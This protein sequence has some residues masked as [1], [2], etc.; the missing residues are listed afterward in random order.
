MV[1]EKKSDCRFAGRWAIIL[2]DV[3]DESHIQHAVGFIQYRIP[4]VIEGQHNPDS[5]GQ[6]SLPGVA[7]RTST[8]LL[9]RLYLGVL[10]YTSENHR[11]GDPRILY[12]RW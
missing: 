11:I 1:A 6:A 9:E 4:D 2:S 5:S 8:P 3:V 10:L 12:H 7:I